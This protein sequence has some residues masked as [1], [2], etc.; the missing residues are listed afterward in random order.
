MRRTFTLAVTAAL[1][2]G[3]VASPVDA[4]KKKP[5]PV[6][7]KYFFHGNS[8]IGEP[9]GL[10]GA[11]GMEPFPSMDATEP[12]GSNPRSMMVISYVGG[13]NTACRGSFLAPVWVGDVTGRVLGEATV[14]FDVVSSPTA[15]VNVQIFPDQVDFNCDSAIPAA[16]LVVPL[17]AGPG[18]VE[19]TFENLDFEVVGKVMVQI[20]PVLGTPYYA[21]VLYDSADFPSSFEFSCI[22]P[23]GQTSCDPEG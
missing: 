13:P 10:N 3:L 2:M 6:V 8:P 14:A 18:H 5:K 4:K 11:T 23:K 21:R 22:P 7:T 1:M 15:A 9:D 16:S 19:A 17:P 20:S 12:S